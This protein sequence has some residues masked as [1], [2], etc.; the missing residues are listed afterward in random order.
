MWCWKALNK[1][2]KEKKWPRHVQKKKKKKRV[3]DN[4]PS[5][6]HQS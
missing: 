4:I 6:G 5:S 1:G 3:Y 2:Y